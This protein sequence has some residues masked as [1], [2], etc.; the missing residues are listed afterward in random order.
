M[1]LFKTS[2]VVSAMVLASATM[3]N[4]SVLTFDDVVPDFNNFGTYSYGG[5]DFTNGGGFAAIWPGYSPNSNGTPNLIYGYPF[6]NS[7]T[8]TKTGGGLFDFNS[9]EMAISWYDSNPAETISINGNPFALSQLLTTY[10]FNLLGVSSV[11]ITGFDSGYWVADNINVNSVSAVPL[12]AALPLF[13]TGLAGV[14][15]LSRRRRRKTA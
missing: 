15:A 2:F 6:G 11:S 13:L 3:A 7:L 1:K 14:A 9:I 5:Y 8:I 12:P 4:A 10:N